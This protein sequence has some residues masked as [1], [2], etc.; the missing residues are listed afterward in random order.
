MHTSQKQQTTPPSPAALSAAPLAPPCPPTNDAA[1]TP[2]TPHPAIAAEHM[3]LLIPPAC[4]I[5][6]SY[7]PLHLHLLQTLL[8]TQPRQSQPSVPAQSLTHSCMK[9]S[10]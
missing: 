10:A 2:P 3:L 9:L 5:V 6:T 1:P 4:A 7:Y 8:M